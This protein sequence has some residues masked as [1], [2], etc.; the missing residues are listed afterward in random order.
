MSTGASV[1]YRLR[2]NK[3]VDRELFL[4][5]LGRLAATLKIE[6]YKYVGLGGAFLEEFRLIHA[7][8]GI[9]DMICV[10]RDKAVHDRQLFNRPIAS[11]QCIHKALED[12]LSES[13]FDRPIVLW[14]DYTAPEE[15]RS[16]IECFCEQAT[17]LPLYSIVRI[18]LNTN[19]SSLG[20]PRPDEVRVALFPDESNDS[21]PTLHE[22][23]LAKLR[24]R[25]AEYVPVEFTSQQLETRAFGPGMIQIMRMAL[26]K[27]MEG[28]FDRK[29]V[30]A[31]STHYSDGQPMVTATVIVVPVEDVQVEEVVKAWSFRRVDEN[32][33]VIEMPA[34]STRERLTLEASGDPANC[35][36]Y[37]LPKSSL[38]ADPFESF[39][40]L[41][42][43]FPHFATVDL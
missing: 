40:L 32:P 34:L 37:Q 21:R 25:L 16:Q 9:S 27:S 41:Y 38:N 7:R 33:I 26:D 42:R 1:A 10:E 4:S 2:P 8:T 24:A 18:T 19:P 14:L 17:T 5:L 28:Y 22:W 13:V 43:V 29:A 20:T 30:W 3:A 11:V 36:H 23:R 12:Y 35:L 6:N 39:K 31:F 15:I